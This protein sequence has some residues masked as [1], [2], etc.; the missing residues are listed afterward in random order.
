[1]ACLSSN[2]SI[3]LTECSSLLH[4]EVALKLEFFQLCL[5]EEC[6]FYPSLD[7]FLQVWCST[8]LQKKWNSESNI[9]ANSTAWKGNMNSC[10]KQ[11]GTDCCNEDKN[12][13]ENQ[14]CSWS[15]TLIL[16]IL[17]MLYLNT[18]V[19]NPLLYQHPKTQI[20]FP[21]D[22]LLVNSNPSWDPN[23]LVVYLSDCMII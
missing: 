14:K 17:I 21:L 8:K 1:M 11:I 19:P 10:F 16:N 3:S 15:S 23:L 5:E 13:N 12:T 22:K 4:L 20:I 6:W 18:K 7:K 9:L 2:T